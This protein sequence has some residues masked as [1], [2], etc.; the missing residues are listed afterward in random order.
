MC[1]TYKGNKD[2]YTNLILDLCYFLFYYHS[3]KSDDIT[4][5]AEVDE[6]PAAEEEPTTPKPKEENTSAE[7]TPSTEAVSPTTSEIHLFV[8]QLFA[9]VDIEK[10]TVKTIN[11]S[12]ANHFGLTKAGIKRRKK[13]IRAR[14][15]GLVDNVD[16]VGNADLVDNTDFIENIPSE[17]GGRQ[18]YFI[19]DD[20]REDGVIGSESESVVRDIEEDE[21]LHHNGFIASTEDEEDYDLGGEEISTGVSL[22]IPDPSA[23]HNQKKKRAQ[24]RAR[25]QLKEKRSARQS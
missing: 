14:L 20:A 11:C 3:N 2:V 16:L 5:D 21:A 17:Q 18:N 10:A 1:R 19:H 25:A 22:V 12:V 24:K 9:N 8:D 13:Q 23:C 7:S 15:I 4:K 6:E